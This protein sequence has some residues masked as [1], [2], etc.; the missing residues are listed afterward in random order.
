MLTF[1]TNDDSGHEFETN[2]IYRSQTKKNKNKT[3]QNSKIK[4]KKST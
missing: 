1:E 2:T 3:K 4:G